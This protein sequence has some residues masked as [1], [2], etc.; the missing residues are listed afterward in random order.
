M[1]SK[2]ICAFD[3]VVRKAT[4]LAL[5]EKWCAGCAFYKTREQLQADKDHA[6]EIL[7]AKGLEP[8]QRGKIMTT[9]PIR[10]RSEYD[11]IFDKMEG[12]EE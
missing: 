5:K 10:E 6:A 7:K 11:R 2:E 12:V 9:R 1:S 3:L 8:Y 4:C